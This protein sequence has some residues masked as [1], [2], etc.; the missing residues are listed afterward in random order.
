[1]IISIAIESRDEIPTIDNLKVKLIEE[2]ARQYDRNTKTN[3]EG[4]DTRNSA[5][6]VKRKSEREKRTLDN[7]K[8]TSA[9]TNTIQRKMLQL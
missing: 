1:M 7:A 8:D 4:D 5:L 9:K 6:F 3:W 2:E